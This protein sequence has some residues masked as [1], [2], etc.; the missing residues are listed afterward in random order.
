LNTEVAHLGTIPASPVIAQ[1]SIT[2]DDAEFG[3][4]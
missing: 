3:K 2:L 1:K 4:Y